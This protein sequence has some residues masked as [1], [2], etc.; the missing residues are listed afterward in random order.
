MKKGLFCPALSDLQDANLRNISQRLAIYFSVWFHNLV[1][2]YER[3]DIFYV[4]TKGFL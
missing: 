2:A 4:Y 1:T 3:Q